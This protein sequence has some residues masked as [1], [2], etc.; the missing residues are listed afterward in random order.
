MI[1]FK[2]LASVP[3][4]NEAVYSWQS[5][6][7]GEIRMWA[8]QRMEKWL[9]S[10]GVPIHRAEISESSAKMFVRDR[11]IE[12]HRLDYLALHPHLLT[13]PCIVLDLEEGTQLILD[14]HHRYVALAAICL[15][16]TSPS[17][18]D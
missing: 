11:G 17:P 2:E 18:R 10:S 15:L 8:I 6:D 4:N 9:P 16:Y 1:E 12:R 5:P 14:G 3:G 7:T 13:N